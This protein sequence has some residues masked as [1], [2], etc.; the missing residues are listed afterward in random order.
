[1]QYVFWLIEYCLIVYLIENIMVYLLENV[2][3][4]LLLV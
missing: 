1:M 2:R 4:K 3:K